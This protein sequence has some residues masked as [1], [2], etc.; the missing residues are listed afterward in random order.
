MPKPFIRT[1]AFVALLFVL[2]GCGVNPVT[3]KREL[4]LVSESKEISIGQENYVPGSA[5]M[6]AEARHGVQKMETG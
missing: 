1:C 5:V 4:Q 6:H 2:S 3:H